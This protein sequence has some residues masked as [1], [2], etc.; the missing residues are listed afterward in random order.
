MSDASSPTQRLAIFDLDG[1]LVD[2]LPDIAAALNAA[3]RDA[4]LEPFPVGDTARMVGHGARLL[5]ER[6]LVARGQPTDTSSVD[7]LWA[8][9]ITHYDAHPCD[10]TRLYPGALA[11]LDA[12]A[13]DGWAVALC[14]NKP[15]AIAQQVLDALGITDRFVSIIGGQDSLPLKPAPDMVLLNLCDA[16]VMADRA[17]MIG[18]SPADLEAARA[19]GIPVI[20][21]AHGYS[22]VPVATL[23]ADATLDHFDQLL[24]ALKGMRA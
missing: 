6:A 4:G 16:N 8:A 22:S 7:A 14:T 11:A 21:M 10:L 23:G 18:D 1:T 19:A 24:P 17:V 20:L 2:S 9:F 5:V 15:E 13:A 3:L 12:L